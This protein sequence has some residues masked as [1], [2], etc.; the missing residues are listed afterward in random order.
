VK[1]TR[2]YGKHDMR[3]ENVLDP[4]IQDP[5]DAII[6]VTS[7]AIRGSDLHI[8]DGYIPTVDKGDTVLIRFRVLGQD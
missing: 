7:T 4:V 3:V 8:V 5:R 2:W 1:A 6:R